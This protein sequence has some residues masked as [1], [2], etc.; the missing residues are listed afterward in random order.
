MD[1]NKKMVKIMS[2]QPNVILTNHR[3]PVFRFHIRNEPI[4]VPEEVAVFLVEKK[5]HMIYVY[6]DKGSKIISKSK[7]KVPQGGDENNL[8]KSN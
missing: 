4:S 5:P 1:K 8:S 3:D 7:K 6:N 2:K